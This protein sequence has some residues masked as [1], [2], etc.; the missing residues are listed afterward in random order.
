LD[1]D[2]NAGGDAV[3]TA[4]SWG[5]VFAAVLPKHSIIISGES[6]TSGMSGLV[7]AL[8]RAPPHDTPG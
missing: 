4:S 5:E 2:H 6:L 1:V 3:L 8:N 7:E